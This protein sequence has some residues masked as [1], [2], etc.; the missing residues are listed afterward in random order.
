[1]NPN[2]ETEEQKA[3]T[4]QD[5]LSSY[6]QLLLASEQAMQ[7]EYDKSVMTL[8]GGALGVSFA[9]LKDIVGT[10]GLSHGSILL[11]SWI[12]WGMSISFILASFFTSGQSLRKAVTDTD[13]KEIYLTLAKSK[14]VTA[15]KWLNALAGVCFF[16]GVTALVV[17]VS[18]NLPK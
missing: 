14:W 4:F 5:N 11:L 16:L 9:Y 17:F 13:M 3:N 8:S 1:M 12:L 18:N 6:R 15:T 2:P 7:S 10:Q